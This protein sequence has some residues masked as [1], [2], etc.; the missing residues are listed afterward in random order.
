[1]QDQA[2]LTAPA[3]PHV[4]LVDDDALFLKAFATNIQAAGYRVTCFSDPAQALAALTAGEAPDACVLDWNMP[5]LDGMEL[6]KRMRDAGVTAPVMFLTSLDQPVFEELALDGGAID[7][8][9]KTKSSAVILKRLALIV[10][11]AK[12][13][14]RPESPPA[15][16]MVQFGDLTLKVETR[17]ALWRGRETPLS[18]GEFDVVRLLAGRAGE[19]V[20][21]REIY[22]LVRGDGFFA[23][24]GEEGYRANVR[25]MI[26]RIRRK[27][28]DIDPEFDALENY[29][30]FGYRWRG[31]QGGA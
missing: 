5:G 16:S 31:G 28:L 20:S 25:A 7:F 1:M 13:R 27:F 2:D 4:V 3:R 10:G 22:D 9:E 23:G 21:Y 18:L 12:R 26:K 15:S 17:R 30:G 19:D 29:P 11:G 6:L 14:D 24:Q 8:V